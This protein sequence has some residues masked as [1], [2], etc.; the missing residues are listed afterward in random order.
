MR[1]EIRHNHDG[2][3]VPLGPARPHVAIVSEGQPCWK[4]LTP[5]VKKVAKEK[6]RGG[7]AYFY[8]HCFRCPKC[9]TVYMV[10]SARRDFPEEEALFS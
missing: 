6:P 1:T 4:C 9:R 3:R 7:R 2:G 10:E 8:E 5:V